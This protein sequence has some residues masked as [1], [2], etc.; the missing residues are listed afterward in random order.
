LKKIKVNDGELKVGFSARGKAGASC[1]VD[2]VSLVK[3]E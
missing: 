1:Q 2:D 3:E